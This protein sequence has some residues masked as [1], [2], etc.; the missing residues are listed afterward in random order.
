MSN[1]VV[2]PSPVLF[3]G[4]FPVP[5]PGWAYECVWDDC[6]AGRFWRRKNKHEDSLAGSPP[7]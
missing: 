6:R 5:Y 7:P 2:S 1:A 4:V 3:P